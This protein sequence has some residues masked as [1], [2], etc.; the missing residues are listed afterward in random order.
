LTNSEATYNNVWGYIT[1]ACA[2]YGS[3]DVYLMGHGT[4]LVIYGGPYLWYT[5]V[6][7]VCYDAVYVLPIL[8]WNFLF[9]SDIVSGTYDYSTLRTGVFGFCHSYDFQ[10]EFLNPGGST[11]HWRFFTGPQG[12]VY[13]NYVE[14]FVETWC[15]SWYDDDLDT[16]MSWYYAKN[17]AQ[18][19]V[20]DGDPFSYNGYP[21]YA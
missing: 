16:W 18:Q 12:I 3:V 10:D 19:Y 20:G 4:E 13:D 5:R 9:P 21:I 1:W 15:D 11:S 6:A 14:A 8:F 17:A 2:E 7:Y